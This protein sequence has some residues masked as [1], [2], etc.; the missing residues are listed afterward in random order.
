MRNGAACN[1]HI[2]GRITAGT[3][4]MSTDAPMQGGACMYRAGAAL[5]AKR[6]GDDAGQPTS[7]GPLRLSRS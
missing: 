2:S 4:Y 5:R 3:L 1:A 7:T 6:V